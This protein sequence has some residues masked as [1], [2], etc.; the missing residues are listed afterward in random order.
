MEIGVL[1][2]QGC[3]DP[4]L[5]HLESLGVRGVPV[6]NERELSRCSGLI[7]PGGESSAML[8]LLDRDS[9]FEPLQSYLAQNPAWG[10]CAG[11]ILLSQE[12]VNPAQRSFG[13]APLKAERN[14]YGSQLDSFKAEVAV[15]GFD[16]P[17]PVDF[18][19]APLLT[20]LSDRVET[21]AVHDGDGVLFRSG[22]TLISAFH[23]ELNN[24]SRLHELFLS[25]VTS[26]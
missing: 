20:A 8:K 19:R 18:I 15:T 11:A 6:R 17:I 26:V 4:H 23:T 22:H 14:H 7:L 10:I 21:L 12:V 13:T 24:D 5:S 9:F 16:S 1:A 2:L 3:I 25:L